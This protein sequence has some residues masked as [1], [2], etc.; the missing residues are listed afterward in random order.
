MSLLLVLKFQQ[1]RTLLTVIVASVFILFRQEIQP[2]AL[3]VY[4]A[5]LLLIYDPFSILSAAFF[6]LMAYMFYST[7]GLSNYQQLTLKIRWQQKKLIFAG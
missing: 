6:C 1:S 3:L 7:Q 2:F 4:S 5:S